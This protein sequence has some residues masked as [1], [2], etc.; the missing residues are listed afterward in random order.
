M[1]TTILQDTKVE[2]GMKKGRGNTAC[3]NIKA[4]ARKKTRVRGSTQKE[5]NDEETTRECYTK[6]DAPG[7]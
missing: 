6:E 2:E 1:S 3:H 7:P 4:K 5:G